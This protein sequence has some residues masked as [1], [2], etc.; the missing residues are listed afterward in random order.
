MG[1]LLPQHREAGAVDERPAAQIDLAPLPGRGPAD[2]H[3]QRERARLRR[4]GD[5]GARHADRHVVHRRVLSLAEAADAEVGDVRPH[6]RVRAAL[7][8]VVHRQ[9]DGRHPQLLLEERQQSREATRAAADV[10]GADLA[11]AGRAEA[12]EALAHVAH[13]GRQRRPQDL[14]QA[15]GAATRHRLAGR[16]QPRL[17]TLDLFGALTVQLQRVGDR[18]RQVRATARDRAREHALRVAADEQV[19]AGMPEIQ[20]RGRR[21]HRIVERARPVDPQRP[22]GDGRGVEGARV[23]ARAAER[24]QPGGDVVALRRD[25]EDV[26]ALV[27]G[28][29]DDMVEDDVVQRVNDLAF[30]LVP[31]DL[32]DLPCVAERELQRAER[33]QIARHRQVRDRLRGDPGQRLAHRLHLPRQ[34]RARAVADHLLEGAPVHRLPE[35]DLEDDELDRVG[36]DVDATNGVGHDRSYSSRQY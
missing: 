30:E 1:G 11:V 35:A 4:A 34:Q 27:G 16:Q 12:R 36:A 10:Q 32:V 18:R 13:Q 15:R 29:D 14:V 23:D 6:L 28:A 5:R 26:G 24:V 25:G 8:A 3:R 9:E 21:R 22:V 20:D 17:P 33:Q 31:D 19:G 7:Q 2:P